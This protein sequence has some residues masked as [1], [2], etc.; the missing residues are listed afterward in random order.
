MKKLEYTA[1]VSE[2]ENMEELPADCQTLLK[3]AIEARKNAYA[4]YSHFAVGSAV[5]LENGITITGNNQE[6]IAFPSGLCAERTALFYA[7]ANHP[8]KSVLKIA[9]SSASEQVNVDYPVYPCGA[10]RQVMAEYENISG[11]PIEII[12]MGAT[13]KIHIVNGLINLMPFAFDNDK[14][15]I[16]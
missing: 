14:I 6:N 8:D 12:L 7:N 4:P 3:S 15:H 9:V 5:L 1:V 13:G 2:Y 11:N 10:C 16:I